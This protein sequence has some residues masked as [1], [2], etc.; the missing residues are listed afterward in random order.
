FDMIFIVKDE[1]DRGRDERIAKHVMGIHMD[2]AGAD[3]AHA[4]ADISVEKMKRYISYCKQSVP[5]CTLAP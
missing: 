2:G 1:H 4:A 5:P 3:D